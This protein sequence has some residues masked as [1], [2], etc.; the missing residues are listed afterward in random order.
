[1]SKFDALHAKSAWPPGEAPLLLASNVHSSSEAS[2]SL[3]PADSDRLVAESED[4]TAEHEALEGVA[5][6]SLHGP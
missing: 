1:M 2:D 5:L 3:T 6:V 4:V